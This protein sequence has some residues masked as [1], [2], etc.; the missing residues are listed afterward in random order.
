MPGVL[1]EGAWRL[2]VLRGP[3][4]TVV[5][6]HSAVGTAS[7]IPIPIRATDP[8][9]QGSWSLN[10]SC[11]SVKN[12]SFTEQL[13]RAYLNSKHFVPALLKLFYFLIFDSVNCKSVCFSSSSVWT[14]SRTIR[15]TNLFFVL[16]CFRLFNTNDRAFSSTFC[17]SYGFFS[18]I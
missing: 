16:Q 11:C 10:W 4:L 8:K 13:Q 1:C 3:I 9:T 6:S 2:K 14:F 12:A 17:S 18:Y 5:I 7:S 15:F